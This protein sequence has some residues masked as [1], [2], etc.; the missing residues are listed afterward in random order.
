MIV[1]VVGRAAKKVLSTVFFLIMVFLLVF[2]VLMLCY[3][4]A[5]R[6]IKKGEETQVIF[7]LSSEVEY[8]I[9][10]HSF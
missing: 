8:M 6:K 4:C 3:W 7:Y 1:G 5:Q 2:L 10:F 9:L